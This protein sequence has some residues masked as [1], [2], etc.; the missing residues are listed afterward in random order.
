[1]SPWAFREAGAF[2]TVIGAEPN[3]I[4]LINFA[5]GVEFN[6]CYARRIVVPLGDTQATVIALDDLRT[7]KRAVNRLQDQADLEALDHQ[8][9]KASLETI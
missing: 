9:Q 2:V 4:E 3:R 8:A 6:E 7:N 5:D 1:M